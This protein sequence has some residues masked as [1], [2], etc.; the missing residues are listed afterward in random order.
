MSTNLPDDEDFT[1]TSNDGKS[2]KKKKLIKKTMAIA[3]QIVNK[4]EDGE[5]NFIDI[6]I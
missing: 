3:N 5:M 2:K 4:N 6:Q 1:I